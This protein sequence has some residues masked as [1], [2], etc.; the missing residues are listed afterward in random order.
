VDDN[1]FV[2]RGISEWRPPLQWT[3]TTNDRYY[4]THVRS[5]YAIKSGSGSQTATW[6]IPISAAGRYD[7]YYYMFRQENRGRGRD[8]GGRRGEDAEYNFKVKYNGDEEKAYINT[9]N[10]EDG[11]NLLGT[12]FFDSDTI[13]VVLTNEFKS[14][15][16]TA[17]AVKAVRR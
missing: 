16:V 13:E 5:A 11:W 2:Y 6:K 9:R 17:D 8:G 4:G 15:L 14:R 12:Y 3:L 10:I 7:L 1:S